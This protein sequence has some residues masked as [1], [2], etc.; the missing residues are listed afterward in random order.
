[1]AGK[2]IVIAGGGDSAVDW[3]LSLSKIA[4]HVTLVHR[5]DRFRAAPESVRQLIEAEGITLKTP[6]QLT[7]LQGDGGVLHGVAVES[8]EGAA[9]VID[10]D[11]LLPFYGL[12]S[13]LGP[14]AD[15][16]LDVQGTVIP[17]NP[18]TAATA[19]SGIYAV[20]DIADY[21]HKLKLILTGFAECAQAA[22]DIYRRVHPDQPLHFEHSTTKGV[23]NI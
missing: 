3:A 18:H 6:Y 1:M 17:I 5:R 16:G 14:I 9:E 8:L 11:I 2:R 15:W 23:P 21:P 12:A 10:A 19:Q 22:H 20:G 7:G 4:A 13:D